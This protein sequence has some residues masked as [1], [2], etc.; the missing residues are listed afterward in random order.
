[1]KNQSEEKRSGLLLVCVAIAA[2]TSTAFGGLYLLT[3]LETL[4]EWVTPSS[5]SAVVCSS[6]V[7]WLVRRIPIFSSSSRS[8]D[9]SVRI[10]A[11]D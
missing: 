3:H 7:I 10:A 6:G 1:M 5:A 8:I 9:E 2:L 4:P 11:A